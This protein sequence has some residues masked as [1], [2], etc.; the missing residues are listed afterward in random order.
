MFRRQSYKR[1]MVLKDKISLKWRCNTSSLIITIPQFNL[2][3]D[4]VPLRS[5]RLNCTFQ[6]YFSFIGLTPVCKDLSWGE[7]E[8]RRWKKSLFFFILKESFFSFLLFLLLTKVFAV[9]VDL[10]SWRVTRVE[11]MG[12]VGQMD[13]LNERHKDNKKDKWTN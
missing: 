11:H 9:S 3:W 12:Q 6:G 10:R 13:K 4:N 1:N 7:R 5:L 8:W 2:N